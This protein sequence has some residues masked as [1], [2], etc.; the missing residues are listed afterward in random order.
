MSSLVKLFRKCVHVR[1]EGSCFTEHRTELLSSVKVETFLHLF[2][3]P[4]ETENFLAPLC[5]AVLKKCI[6]QDPA[7]AEYNRTEEAGLFSKLVNPWS[8]TVL[9]LIR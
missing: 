2:F 4:R 7:L 1:T 3:F 6:K 9:T 5:A 8:R